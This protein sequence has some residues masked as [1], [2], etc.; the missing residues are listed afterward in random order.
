MEKYTI[1]GA[2]IQGVCIALA[3]A[4][5][6]HD[7]ILI[8]KK[9]EPLLGASGTGEGRIH[10]G[11]L[12]SNDKSYKTANFLLHAGLHFAPLLEKYTSKKINWDYFASYPTTYIVSK[13][14]LLTKEEITKCYE[15]IEEKYKAE[16][17]NSN[18]HYC[19]KSINQLWEKTDLP[20]GINRNFAEAAYKTCEVAINPLTFREFLND[21]IKANKK[22]KLLT[23]HHVRNVSRTWQGFHL[24]GEHSQKKGTWH[25]DT[26]IVV[27]CLW[28]SRLEIDAQLGIEPPEQWLYRLKHSIYIEIN[29][30]LEKFTNSYCFIVGSYGD[31]VLYPKN[32]LVYLSWYPTCKTKNCTDLRP[33]NQWG[34]ITN[35]EQ[36]TIFHD[37]ILALNNIIPGISSGQ[38]KYFK[39][40]VIFS[41]GN[42]KE[43]ID[44]KQSE[45][46]KRYKIGIYAKDGYFSVDPGK[47]TCAPFFAEEFVNTMIK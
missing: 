1:L 41:W 3:L 36:Q 30:E 6:G 43:D 28:D 4:Q 7:V 46:H 44:V 16:Y 45:L 25:L 35:E 21:I 23:E 13:K 12:Y 31:I 11:F 9:T 37:T 17:K 42:E 8:E 47:Y 34:K 32:N 39:E 22:I 10:L 40:G 18:L 20:S 2:G 24:E 5:K 33:P 14:S 38:M 19:G 26:E 29:K 15:T 27:N